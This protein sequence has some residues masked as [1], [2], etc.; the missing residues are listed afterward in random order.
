MDFLIDQ[1][2]GTS[3]PGSIL[4]G[5]VLR[6][7]MFGQTAI[8][9]AGLADITPTSSQT[10]DYVHKECHTSPSRTRTYNLAVNSRSLYQLS[11]RGIPTNRHK[12]GSQTLKAVL[13]Q[14][15]FRHYPNFNSFV[16]MYLFSAAN[17]A[18][19]CTT[20]AKQPIIV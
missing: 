8:Q 15:S 4:C 6:V 5:L 1:F 20:L 17:I 14:I 9:V 12:S 16:K 3:L 13:V 18:K 10:F 19:S 7:V 2:P 11:Y